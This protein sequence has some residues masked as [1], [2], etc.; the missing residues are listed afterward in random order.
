MI[1]MPV[2]TT[3]SGILSTVFLLSSFT[4]PYG[5]CVSREKDLYIMG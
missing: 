2:E 4:I 3:A 1:R 5:L